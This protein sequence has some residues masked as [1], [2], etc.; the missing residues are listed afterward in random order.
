[1]SDENKTQQHPA[2]AY[3]ISKGFEDSALMVDVSATQDTV[4]SFLEA[5]GYT[6]IERGVLATGHDAFIYKTNT[7][8]GTSF[9]VQVTVGN[10]SHPILC[11]RFIDLHSYLLT[12]GYTKSY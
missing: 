10:E 9:A 6:F 8:K 2:S 3:S 1:M 4:A 11:S 12:A 7:Y 5:E